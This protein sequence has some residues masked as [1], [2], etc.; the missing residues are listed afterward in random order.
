[1]LV[2]LHL[3]QDIAWNI[4]MEVRGDVTHSADGLPMLFK[5]PSTLI[6]ALSNRTS[7]F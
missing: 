5:P 4:F 7:T 1:M 2:Y 6:A 3:E